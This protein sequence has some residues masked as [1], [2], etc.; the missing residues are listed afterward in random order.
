MLSTEKYFC[1]NVVTC[2]C[3]LKISIET[4]LKVIFVNHTYMQKV[5]HFFP[6]YIIV[7]RTYFWKIFWC[8]FFFRFLRNYIDYSKFNLHVLTCIEIVFDHSLVK[9]ISNTILTYFLR[10]LLYIFCKMR[11]KK[12]YF[13][14]LIYYIRNRRLGKYLNMMQKSYKSFEFINPDLLKFG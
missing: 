6:L 1:Y 12:S 13:G 10:V 3:A 8:Y 5:C 11:V 7:I 9:D 2:T 14:L 4:I